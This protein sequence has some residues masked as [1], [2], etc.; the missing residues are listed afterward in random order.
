MAELASQPRVL[1]CDLT[2]LAAEAA[3]IVERLTPVGHYLEHWPGTVV[4]MRVSDPA[5]RSRLRSANYADRIVVHVGDG[6]AVEA[7]RLLPRLHR[8]TLSL[9]ALPTAPAKAREFVARTL[10]DWRMPSLV[11]P[12]SQVLSEF[13][14]HAAISA[15]TDLEV[16]LSRV[17]TRVRIAMTNPGA[18]TSA[19]VMDLP[20]YPLTGR[21]R[22]LVQALAQAWGVI[23]GR[24]TG[25]TVWAVI[26]A[27]QA[28]APDDAQA[29]RPER[30]GRHR[31]PADADVLTEMHNRRV[32]RH[33]REA[34]P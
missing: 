20:E 2:G 29:R 5:L 34:A 13:V 3:D 14:T 21:S 28:P 8:R 23:P 17:D 24:S 7:H 11:T 22:Q 32:G 6:D 16:S 19:T 30:G 4:L 26:D 15:D 18:N 25:C 1:E 12:A 31:G 27:S 33:R 10:E 9:Q